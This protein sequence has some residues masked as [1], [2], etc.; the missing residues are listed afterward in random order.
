MPCTATTTLRRQVGRGVV[1]GVRLRGRR[2]RAGVPRRA[3]EPSDADT[4]LKCIR[5]DIITVL[6]VESKD[7]RIRE[8]VRYDIGFRTGE[9]D[10]TRHCDRA[11]TRVRRAVASSARRADDAS[12][13][14]RKSFSCSRQTSFNTRKI[15]TNLKA[16]KTLLKVIPSSPN[17]RPRPRG[18]CRPRVGS[19]PRGPRRTRR[20]PVAGPPRRG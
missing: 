20:G 18:P 1:P 9:S 13:R 15:K 19:R 2:G 4:W 3:A 14:R 8:G 11:T 5:T 12:V 7:C 17:P 10:T 6:A 16:I